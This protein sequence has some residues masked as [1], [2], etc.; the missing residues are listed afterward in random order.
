[1]EILAGVD[2]DDATKYACED[3]WMTFK[4]YKAL[5]NQIEPEI[6]KIAY[7]V[8]FPFIMTLLDMEDE[9]IKIDT[10]YF[11]ILEKRT[12]KT[13]ETV[14]EKIYSGCK[15]E[16]NINSPKQLGVI[17]FEE[18]KLPVIK[19]TKTGYS[20][21]ESVL[22]KLEQSH[23]IVPELLKY[24]EL[25]KLQSTYIKPLLTLGS[26]S[27][28]ERIYTSFLQTGTSTGRLS[29]REPNLQNIPTRSKQGREIREGF[30]ARDGFSFIGIDYSQIE[31]RLLAH[32]SGDE[33]LLD[34]FN[35]DLDIHRQTS[36]RLFGESLADE[37][38]GVA[39]SINFGLLY[40]M[41]ARRLSETLKVSQKE[42]KEYIE[43]YFKSFPTLKEYLTSIKD[44]ARKNGFVKTLLGR[45]R[46]F[47]FENTNTMQ[48]LMHEREAVNTLFQGSAADL[49][50]LSMIKI[51]NELVD[52]SSRMLLQIHDE[53]I[54]EVQD[55]YVENFAKKAG[56][57]MMNIYK[58]NVKLEV[59]TSIGKNWGEL[60]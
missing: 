36:L 18:L 20:T 41:G 12:D 7:E 35:N 34:A 26:S 13:L 39:K 25:A 31:L 4:L 32:F 59:S 47:D 44:E 8:E 1:M 38:R 55:E 14:K 40:G 29:S 5:I 42:A 54:F 52:E 50:K 46:Y 19:K 28:C 58:L 16:F 30:V 3:A 23:E 6:L 53:L 37:K 27:S 22:R 15:M 10:A 51:K 33:A 48:L 49:I 17:L 21:D 57:I 43:N 11:K 45:K 56:K 2:I 9:G 24:R 60:K